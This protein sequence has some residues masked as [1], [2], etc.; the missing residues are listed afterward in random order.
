MKV[1]V[2]EFEGRGLKGFKGGGGGGGGRG[3]GGVRKGGD[4]ER[5]V[6]KGREGLKGRGSGGLKVLNEVQRSTPPDETPEALPAMKKL[7]VLVHLN[8]PSKNAWKD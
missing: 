1:K 2:K 3:E 7:R 6:F 8:K 4:V 5:E